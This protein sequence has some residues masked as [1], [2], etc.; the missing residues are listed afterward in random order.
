MIPWLRAVLTFAGF[1]VM[2]LL[3]LPVQWLAVR[4]D[5]AIQRWIVVTFHRGLVRLLGLRI[6][7]NGAIAEARP[8]LIVANHVSWMDIHVLGSIAYLSFIAKSE[9]ARWPLFG[10][11]ARLQHTVFV[12][13]DARRKSASQA[14][15]IA[16]RI[17]AGDAMVLF[18]EGTTADGNK[19]L[20]FKSALFGAVGL[21]AAEAGDETVRIQPVSIAYTRIHGLPMGRM[22]HR[23]VSYVGTETIVTSALRMLKHGGVD[24]TVSFGEPID[25]AGVAGRK[26]LA[27]TMEETVAALTTDT[28]YRR[29]G[30]QDGGSQTGLID[31]KRP[32]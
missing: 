23:L 11:F 2:T 27:R 1:A 18:P 13:R 16:G 3:L 20:P 8:L 31:A 15:E 19:L 4:F 6:Q 21:V 32:R 29:A 17:A 14:S 12:E 7:V 25:Y 24:V 10:T 22:H 5:W 9:V 30:R 26:Q 28:K